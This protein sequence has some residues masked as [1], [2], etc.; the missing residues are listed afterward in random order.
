M[1][2]KSLIFVLVLLVAGYAEAQVYKKVVGPVEVE[3]IIYRSQA[4]TIADSE[5]GGPAANTNT[6]ITAGTLKVTCGDEDGCELTL[7]EA[8]AV[9]GQSL[10]IFNVGANA[11]TLI[12][13]DGVVELCGDTDKTADSASFQYVANAWRQLGCFEDVGG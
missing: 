11:L 4:L 2:L 9:D 13:S 5:D 3:R 1:K 7:S 6:P 8:G 12:D 10:N